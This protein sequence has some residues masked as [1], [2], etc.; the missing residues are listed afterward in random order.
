MPHYAVRPFILQFQIPEKHVLSILI[1]HIASTPTISQQISKL[2]EDIMFI[3]DHGSGPYGKLVAIYADDANDI[4]KIIE[5][6]RSYRSTDVPWI[7]IGG[8]ESWTVKTTIL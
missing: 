2:R 3:Y 6:R 4:M 7:I 1:N 8:V 5:I